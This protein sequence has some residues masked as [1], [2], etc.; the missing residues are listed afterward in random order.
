MASPAAA[1]T[2]RATA[3]N[4]MTLLERLRSLKRPADLDS[5]YLTHGIH[6][7]A[8]K[9]IP[10]LP[11][12]IIEEHTNERHTVFDPFCGSGTSLLEAALLGRKSIGTDCHPIATLI[13]RAKTTTLEP[14]ELEQVQRFATE[15]PARV[16]PHLSDS[17]EIPAMRSLRQW[18]SPPAIQELAFL[19]GRIRRMPADNV[20]QF[21]ECMLSSIIV[22]VSN[23]ESETR[24]AAKL[25]Q[26][27]SGHTIFRF[28][29]KLIKELAA[30]ENLSK[31]PRVRRNP[32]KIIMADLTDPRE[33]GFIEPDSVD[34]IVTSPPYPN[35]Y[36]YYL[37]HKWRLIWLG[38]DVDRVK[39]AEIG[40]R[41]EYSSKR[42][43]IETFI[44]RMHLAFI[45]IGRMLKPSKLAY[46]FVGD[47]VIDG[48]FHDMELV[49]R[50]ISKGTSLRYVGGSNY[51]LSEVTRSFHEK[52]SANCH[53][54]KKN[55]QK[56]QHVLVFEKVNSFRMCVSRSG[57]T[58]AKATPVP[59]ATRV[60]L[61]KNIANGSTVSKICGQ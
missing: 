47:A 21:L 8:A 34:L 55:Q 15:L 46:F 33:I 42:A 23:Q 58:R 57:V 19:R 30:I 24:Y 51:E 27:G 9:Y 59:I 38:F 13:A 39:Q 28:K 6:P 4:Q 26:I 41:N 36:D 17:E 11:R 7:Y 22:S 43:P 5:T 31:I 45:S 3:H 1:T 32:P 48:Q 12:M 37:Y 52:A 10:Q 60:S 18:F 25:K 20:R 61:G 16:F 49:Y 2:E 56:K 53:G 50:E 54:G 14:C 44:D 40:S 29:R 35:S